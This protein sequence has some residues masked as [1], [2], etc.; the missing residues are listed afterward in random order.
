MQGN[1]QRG[2]WRRRTLAIVAAVAIVLLVRY[3]ETGSFGT[4]T[5]E[6]AGV[7]ESTASELRT[8]RDRIRRAFADEESGVWVEADGVVSRLLPDDND[9]SRHQ[10]FIVE[11]GE[12]HTVLISHNIDLAPY[13]DLDRGDRVVFRGRYEWNDRGG[14][15]HWT[16]HDPRGRGPGGWITVDGRTYR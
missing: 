13:V 3:C 10:R 9:G 6:P 8:G 16:H 5:R 4:A 15:V 1:W 14:V 12:G 11:L 7:S 2:S